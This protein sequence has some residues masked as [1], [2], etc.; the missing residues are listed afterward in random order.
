MMLVWLVIPLVLIV[1]AGYDE[2]PA[3]ARITS[4]E[5]T[6]K[7]LQCVQKISDAKLSEKIMSPK[8]Q[9]FCGTLPE[10]ITC[11]EGS[12]LIFKSSDNSPMCVT[13]K[14]VEKLVER[15]WAYKLLESEKQ[16]RENTV[17]ENTNIQEQTDIFNFLS[18]NAW[19]N[20]GCLPT[21]GMLAPTCTQLELN[22]N[23]NYHWTAFSDYPE[24]DQS[25]K[26]NF[27]LHGTDSGLVLFDNGSLIP[28]KKVGGYLLFEYSVFMPS[29]TIE[30][31]QEELKKY[32]TD[33]TEITPS[34]T[35]FKLPQHGWKKA[36][37]FDLNMHPDL[38]IFK[39]DGRFF[40]SYRNGQCS[41][42][43]VWGLDDKTIVSISNPNDCVPRIVSAIN[44]G[45]KSSFEND[46]LI[47]LQESYYPQDRMMEK[48][49]F[50][51]DSY[52][53]SITV[54]GEFSGNFEKNN[55]TTI[56]FTF[57]NVAGIDKELGKFTISILTCGPP[58]PNAGC[59]DAKQTFTKDY[60]GISLHPTEFYHDSIT[61]TPIPTASGDSLLSF[62]LQFK[63]KR[64]PYSANH[65]YVVHIE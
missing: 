56:D 30:Y 49:I 16:Y 15:G 34:D 43:G 65:S 20:L 40:A 47:F 36:N 57:Q 32:F 24:R 29:H 64:Q 51:F 44:A 21:Q 45:E 60:G 1:I 55:P 58:Q 42:E 59:S 54:T 3:E 61:I 48:N 23:G 33:L 38:I 14:T 37:N 8:S 63:D 9:V 2:L 25:G 11:N 39:N 41:H 5:P 28:F 50:T 31:S 6:I 22:K 35:F 62:S 18:N 4:S 26:W 17:I 19:K 10:K 27:I 7:D 53:N 46:V 52:V 13:T 12:Q